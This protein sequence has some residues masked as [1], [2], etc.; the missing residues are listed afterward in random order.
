MYPLFIQ[1]KE[2]KA[3]PSRDNGKGVVQEDE[4]MS[5]P[6]SQTSDVVNVK[7]KDEAECTI[8][9]KFCHKENMNKI[10][11]KFPLPFDVRLSD[12]AKA[13]EV[14]KALLKQMGNLYY[15]RSKHPLHRSE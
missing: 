11:L 1:K 12:L 5:P 13:S 4:P 3:F 8:Q 15:Y 2:V 10:L 7:K 9:L 6:S 14:Q